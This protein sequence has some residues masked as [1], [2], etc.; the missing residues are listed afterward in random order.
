VFVEHFL[1]DARKI[2]ESLRV[3]FYDW[4]QFT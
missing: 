2:D 3:L 4:S 1:R